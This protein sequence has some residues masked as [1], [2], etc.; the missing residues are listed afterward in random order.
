[1]FGAVKVGFNDPKVDPYSFDYRGSPR[2]LPY[3]GAHTLPPYDGFQGRKILEGRRLIHVTDRL[4]D[5]ITCK[6][7]CLGWFYNDVESFLLSLWFL[8]CGTRLVHYVQFPGGR[9]A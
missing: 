9:E 1:V 7:I 4:A 6:I 3:V 8:I 2:L 5:L